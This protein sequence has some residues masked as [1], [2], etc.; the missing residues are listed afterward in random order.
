MFVGNGLMKNSNYYK[1]TK[2]RADKNICDGNCDKSVGHSGHCKVYI[3]ENYI[4]ETWCLRSYCSNVPKIII[5]N[6][7]RIEECYEG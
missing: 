7:C 1:R 4:K 5:K 2:L 3:V 6:W